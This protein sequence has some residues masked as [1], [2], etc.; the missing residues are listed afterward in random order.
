MLEL[1]TSFTGEDFLDKF[2][3]YNLL[4]CIICFIFI[5]LGYTLSNCT[6]NSTFSIKIPMH[7][8]DNDVWKKMHSNLGAYFVSSS[9]V[10]LPI[11]AICENH[12]IVFILMLEILFIIVVPIFVIYFYIRKHLIFYNY[13]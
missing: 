7:L 8:M 9:I 12:Y 3:F 5:F 10:F 13:S 1:F 11:G 6:R 2:N 4:S